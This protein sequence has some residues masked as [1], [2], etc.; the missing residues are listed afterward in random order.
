MLLISCEVF[1]V[2]FDLF[3]HSC[4]HSMY[5]LIIII[6]TITIINNQ[7]NQS[8][9]CLVFNYSWMALP[10]MV[11]FKHHLAEL[12]VTF[13]KSFIVL[14]SNVYWSQLSATINKVNWFDDSTNNN[15][16]QTLTPQVWYVNVDQNNINYYYYYIYNMYLVHSFASSSSPASVYICIHIYI[17]IY[18][19]I[20]CSPQSLILYINIYIY[21]F[22]NH[23][24]YNKTKQ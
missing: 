23:S 14:A 19:C 8:S 24:K 21:I 15:N 5:S 7:V 10:I 12:L 20:V 1:F 13:L 18:I 9:V 17:Y 2:C 3:V 16:R 4:L 6:I 11:Q 22:T